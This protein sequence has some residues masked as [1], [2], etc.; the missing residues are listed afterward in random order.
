[1]SAEIIRPDWP[2]EDPMESPYDYRIRFEL[3]REGYVRTL[4]IL[5]DV[6]ERMPSLFH[7]DRS[8][9]GGGAA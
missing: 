2:E 7:G 6:E 1:M 9:G 5:K 8:Q 4:R 3:W